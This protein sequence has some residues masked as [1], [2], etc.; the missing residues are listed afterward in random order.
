MV[1]DDKV[2]EATLSHYHVNNDLCQA[3]SIDEILNW[4]VMNHFYE[5]VND[6]EY[7]VI[8]T[9]QRIVV[10]PTNKLCLDNFRDIRK[11]LVVQNPINIISALLA[12]LLISFEFLSLLVFDLQFV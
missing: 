8:A 4:L 9:C 1:S 12:E 5:P 6:D 11:A 10:M 2:W 7:W 3:W